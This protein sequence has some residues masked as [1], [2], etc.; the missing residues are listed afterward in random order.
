MKFIVFC[1]NSSGHSRG[2][3]YLDFS[4]SG[5]FL[6][7]VGLDEQHTIILWRWQEPFAVSKQSTG[8]NRLFCVKFRPDSDSRV[9]SAGYS[10]L[11]FW[12]VAG[13]SLIQKKPHIP[14]GMNYKKQ[15][16]LSIAFGPVSFDL[17]ISAATVC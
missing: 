3:C 15:T 14:C 1:I 12:D 5:R 16:M 2:V 17:N 10:H 9:V 4:S 7:T 8:S 6:C 11:N 13:S